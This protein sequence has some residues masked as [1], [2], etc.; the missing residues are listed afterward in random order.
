MILFRF[1]QSP[2]SGDESG[3]ALDQRP[4]FFRLEVHVIPVVAAQTVLE[5]PGVDRAP[6]LFEPAGVDQLAV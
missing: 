3:G 5:Q 6:F 2:D 4:G 1:E